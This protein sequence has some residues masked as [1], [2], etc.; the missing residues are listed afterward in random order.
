MIT[1][2]KNSGYKIS[3][4]IV[5]FVL[6]SLWLSSCG[7]DSESIQAARVEDV[8]VDPAKVHLGEPITV[9][10]TFDGAELTSF[11]GDDSDT[12]NLHTDVV[13]VLPGGVDF[14]TDSSEYDEGLNDDYDARGPNSV[15]LCD[16]G[17]RALKYEFAPGELSTLVANRIR[18][19]AQAFESRGIVQFFA[20]AEETIYTVCGAIPEDSDQLTILP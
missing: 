7:G 11:S 5:V 12:E 13:V 9:T 6:C 1:I 3:E 15:T 19:R 8:R 16:D 4:I 17:S 18:F 2:D 14:I 10:V 20:E